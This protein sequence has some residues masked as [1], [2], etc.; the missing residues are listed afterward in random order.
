MLI[1]LILV[2]IATKKIKKFK[3]FKKVI[4]KEEKT[5]YN[6]NRSSQE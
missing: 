4:D 5:L 3:K 1:I 2:G 6:K